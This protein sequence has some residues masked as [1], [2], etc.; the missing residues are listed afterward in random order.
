MCVSQVI[1]AIDGSGRVKLV[2]KTAPPNTPAAVDLDLEKVLGKMPDKTFEFK[3]TDN[4][5]KPLA[6]PETTNAIDALNRVLRLPSVCS[7]RFLT[8]K[9]DRHVTGVWMG[10]T[11]TRTHRCMSTVSDRVGVCVCVCVCVMYHESPRMAM[12]SM[13]ILRVCV[14]GRPC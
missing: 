14:R 8:N 1:G 7:K 6:L 4:V 11:H 10:C 9:V 12:Y 3:R 2:D 13:L 5:L